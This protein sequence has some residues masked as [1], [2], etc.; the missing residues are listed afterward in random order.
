MTA[1]DEFCRHYALEADNPDSR[2]QYR[3]YLEAGELM[4]CIVGEDEQRERQ[5]EDQELRALS[6]Q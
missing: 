6:N 4:R 5:Q 2:E 1:F 3:Q